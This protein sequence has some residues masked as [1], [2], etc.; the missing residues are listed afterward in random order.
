MAARLRA[1]FAGAMVMVIAVTSLVV[2]TSSAGCETRIARKTDGTVQGASGLHEP[3]QAPLRRAFETRNL[4]V[5]Q[6]SQLH[7]ASTKRASSDCP[8]NRS[9][10]I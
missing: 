3:G 4:L 10:S 1:R 5:E 2:F 7:W 8:R 6:V 9:N